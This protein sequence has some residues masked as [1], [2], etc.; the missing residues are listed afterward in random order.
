MPFACCSVWINRNSG[1][2]IAQLFARG[3]GRQFSVT[4]FGRVSF[5]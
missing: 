5:I 3:Y 4:P 2:L 1:V